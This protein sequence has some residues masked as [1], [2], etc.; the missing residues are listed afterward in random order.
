MKRII[1][2]IE[3]DYTLGDLESM[4]DRVHDIGDLGAPLASGSFLTHG[5]VVAP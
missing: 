3:T 4:A 5:M 2:A 1:I